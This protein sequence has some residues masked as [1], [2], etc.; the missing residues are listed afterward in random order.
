M[1]IKV[2]MISGCGATQFERNAITHAILLGRGYERAL[3]SAAALD[4]FVQLN[5][6][7]PQDPSQFLPVGSVEFLRQMFAVFG[8]PE[9]EPMDY[10]AARY[11][12]P[13]LGR[14]VERVR[15]SAG[16]AGLFVKP[17][18]TK[19]FEAKVMPSI[20]E[21]LLCIEAWVSTPVSFE[22]EWRAYVQ[23]GEIIGIA[24]YDDFEVE[25][26]G[27]DQEIKRFVERVVGSVNQDASIN[28]STY[29]IDVGMA[30]GELVLVELN[31][32]WAT[33]YYSDGMSNAQYLSWLHTR[34]LE[35]CAGNKP[36]PKV[37]T[38]DRVLR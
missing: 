12:E 20:P 7:N 32:A 23:S 19:G 9:P 25:Y 24:R 18:Q 36:K 8:M 13:L 27:S 33:G 6:K 14:H 5:Q 26:Q 4:E 16:H 17:V 31:D 30:D 10:P 28:T 1:T 38:I 15:L 21:N 11:A 34:W 2:L 29:A 22:G 35:I 3:F 37:R